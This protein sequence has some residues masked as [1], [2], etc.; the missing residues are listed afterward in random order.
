MTTI[1]QA[2]LVKNREAVVAVV[3]V[4]RVLV[5]D[6]IQDLDRVRDQDRIDAAKAVTTRATNMIR[7]LVLRINLI[8][9]IPSTVMNE[10]KKR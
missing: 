2:F 8:E 6:Q 5:L 9:K 4:I 10:Q 7:L 3:V 1:G